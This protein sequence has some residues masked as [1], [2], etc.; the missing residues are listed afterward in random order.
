MLQIFRWIFE[1]L[2]GKVVEWQNERVDGVWF[3][4]IFL[5]VKGELIFI[6]IF[7]LFLLS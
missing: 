7:H 1:F 4:E 2:I 6:Y 3:G 5:I